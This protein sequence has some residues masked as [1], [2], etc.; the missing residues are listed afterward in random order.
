MNDSI[1]EIIEI[2]KGIKQI[3]EN[4]EPLFVYS[5]DISHLASWS[6]AIAIFSLIAGVIAAY[7][8]YRGYK[9][10]KI[11]ADHLES[12]VPGQMSYYE[13]VGSLINNILSIE[14]IFFG[15]NSY[16]TYPV[17]LILAIAKL[18]EELIQLDK[19]EKNQTCYDEAFKLKIS[20]QNYNYFLD[21][22]LEMSSKDNNRAVSNIAQYIITLSKMEIIKIQTFEGIL[23]TQQYLQKRT[24][25]NERIATYILNRFFECLNLIQLLEI[26]ELDTKRNNLNNNT[27]EQ[28]IYSPY[29]PTVFNIEKYMGEKHEN[30]LSD[31]GLEYESM[32]NYDP[33]SIFESINKGDYNFLSDSLVLPKNQSFQNM[34]M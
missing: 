20:W 12:L 31:V 2:S 17:K 13:I 6:F 24:A 28:Y 27:K 14:A 30:R 10:Q 7:Y 21:S 15:N 23:H 19:Y 8:S 22:L 33:Q 5:I 1:P 25:S 16:K 32:M 18:P 26:R 9:F 3:S 29:L 34:R 11:S 4:T